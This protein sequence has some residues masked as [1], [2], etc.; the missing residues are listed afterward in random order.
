MSTTM[1]NPA[2]ASSPAALPDAST[3]I[4]PLPAV[5][6]PASHAG[7]RAATDSLSEEIRAEAYRLYVDRGCED[8]HDVEDWLAAEALVRARVR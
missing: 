7:E 3:E 5:A 2:R 4:P 1:V 6:D 8:G